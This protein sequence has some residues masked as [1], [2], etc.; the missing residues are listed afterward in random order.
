MTANPCFLRLYSLFNPFKMFNPLLIVH[1]RP[2][3]VQ[4]SCMKT[5]FWNDRLNHES[6]RFL[7]SVVLPW[8]SSREKPCA[9]F[10]LAETS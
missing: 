6:P 4:C 9:L 10:I 2:E 7:E 5:R 8:E 3:E 1:S